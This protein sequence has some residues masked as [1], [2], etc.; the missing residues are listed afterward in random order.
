MCLTP[1]KI[2]A[3]QLVAIKTYEKLYTDMDE[4]AA[5]GRE[6]VDKVEEWLKDFTPTLVNE[7]TGELMDKVTA[8]VIRKALKKELMEG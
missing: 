8:D 2:T 7:K 3:K 4:V 5:S 1:D 6:A